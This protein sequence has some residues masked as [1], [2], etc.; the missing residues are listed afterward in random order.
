LTRRAKHWQNGIIEYSS[1]PVRKNP[2]RVFSC[3]NGGWHDERIGIVSN[4]KQLC[5][6][7]E[8]RTEFELLAQLDARCSCH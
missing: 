8:T 7:R 6:H 3:L 5:R 1:T 2:S 4:D